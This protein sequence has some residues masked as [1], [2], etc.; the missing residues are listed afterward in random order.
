MNKES[1]SLE[2]GLIVVDLN[3]DFM[4]GGALAVTG[5]E[6]VIGPINRLAA[7]SDYG[8]VV[9]TQD[10]HPA[11]HC[12]FETWP[13]HCVAGTPGAELHPL[14]DTAPVAAIIRKG[15]SQDRDS[16][17]GFAD[18]EGHTNGLGEFL[19]GQGMRAV[20]VVGLATDY[21]VRATA[22]DAAKAG[23]RTR[24]ILEACRGVEAGKGD[25]DRALADMKAAG[26]ELVS[27]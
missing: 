18:E 16:Y 10:W 22:I 20:D 12:S 1:D 17:S 6:A 26:V 5:A 4:S 11:D 2:R 27:P 8:V 15:Y 14:V 13:P 23:F 9:A 21:C 7:S 25:V 19:H 24:V 3:L